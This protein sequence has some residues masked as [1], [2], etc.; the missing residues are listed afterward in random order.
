MKPNSMQLENKTASTTIQSVLKGIRY[1]AHEL[2][3]STI[4]REFMYERL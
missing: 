3:F 4:I 1:L 2:G